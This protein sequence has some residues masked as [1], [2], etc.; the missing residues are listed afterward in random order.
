MLTVTVETLLDDFIACSDEIQDVVIISAQGQLLTCPHSI[1]QKS[2]HILADNMLYLANCVSELC[3]WHLEWIIVQ[4]QEGY[5]IFAQ[6]SLDAFLLI[7]AT[8]APTGYL[9]N[10]IQEYLGK[11]QTALQLPNQEVSGAQQSYLPLEQMND[12][13]VFSSSN[14]PTKY[15]KKS[16]TLIQ[17]VDPTFP[18]YLD[19]FAIDYCQKALAE[20][21]GPIAS[22]ICNRILQ[23]NPNL[24]LAEFIHALSKQIPDQQTA[25][26]FQKQLFSSST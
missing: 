6:C 23:Q 26:E 21:I 11:F 2:A 10:H 5:L 25:L 7:K 19:E 18:S 17:Q 20:R 24:R 12:I 8:V 13:G 3:Q 22:L 4:A 14:V 16:P 9:Q 15:L 1:T